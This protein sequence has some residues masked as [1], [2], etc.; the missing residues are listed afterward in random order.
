LT[1]LILLSSE[2]VVRRLCQYGQSDVVS[3]R[4]LGGAWCSRLLTAVERK[5]AEHGGGADARRSLKVSWAFANF[6]HAVR[7]RTTVGELLDLPFARRTGW[8]PTTVRNL[9][10]VVE[11]HLKLGLVERHLSLHLQSSDVRLRRRIR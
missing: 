3:L 1:L 5:R 7:A 2:K 9:Q 4:A 8:L 11:R 10:S 6:T